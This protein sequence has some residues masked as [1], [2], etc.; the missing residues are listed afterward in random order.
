M[1]FVTI[2]LQP[3]KHVNTQAKIELN[4]GKISVADLRVIDVDFVAPGVKPAGI[5]T[6]G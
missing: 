1:I 6:D 3:F 4:H 5:G 2:A